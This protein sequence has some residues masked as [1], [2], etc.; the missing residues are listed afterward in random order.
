MAWEPNRRLQAM[1]EA[2]LRACIE[3]AALEVVED[4]HSATPLLRFLKFRLAAEHA[5][6]ADA[7]RAVGHVSMR[8]GTAICQTVGAEAAAA[9][10]TR[11]GERAATLVID[12]GLAAAR[13]AERENLL[14]DVLLGVE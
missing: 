13:A 11:A 3:A 8:I 10:L 9:P 7:L 2:A 6:K 4:H 5:P 12:E 14:D 1:H